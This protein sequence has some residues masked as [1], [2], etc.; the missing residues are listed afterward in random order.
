MSGP[1]LLDADSVWSEK[2]KMHGNRCEVV[3]SHFQVKSVLEAR[4]RGQRRATMS[5]DLGLSCAEVDL[6]ETGVVL[7]DGH[8]L[9]WQA[10]EQV[11][12]DENGCF[13]LTDQGL[14]RIQAYS[15]QQRRFYSLMPTAGAPTLLNDGFPM[16]RIKGIEPWRDTE[17]K[18]RCL[19]PVRGSVLD[20]ATGLGYT[21]IQIARHAEKVVT[22]EID[23]VVIELAGVNPWSRE[24]FE[25]PKIERLSGDILEL[26]TRFPGRSFDRIMHDPPAFALAGELYSAQFYKELY[27]V[28]KP[29]GR[30]FHYIGDLAS[31]T[32][33]RVLQGVVKRLS[34]AGFSQ[35]R[36]REEAFGILAYP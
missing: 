4:E 13:R 18:V 23:P 22:V 7:P 24:L 15:E 8:E 1:F 33:R 9:S 36:K 35:I 6:T 32:G 20:T 11:A 19:S 28:I 5:L 21:A 29:R 17:L 34:R 31:P 16:H 12:A 25:S 30:L 14:E 27:R 3:L 26:I 2:Q 10:I